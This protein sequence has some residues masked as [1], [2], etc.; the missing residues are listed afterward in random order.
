MIYSNYKDQLTEA[1]FDRN[2]ELS[3]QL[4]KIIRNKLR[5]HYTASVDEIDVRYDRIFG[6]KEYDYGDYDLIFYT[7]ET[8]ELF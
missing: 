7:P 3:K 8:K 6:T 2:E 1:I 5:C 4:V